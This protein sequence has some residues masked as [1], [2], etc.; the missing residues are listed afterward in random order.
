LKL[1]LPSNPADIREHSAHKRRGSDLL[2][3]LIMQL[4][5]FI[6]R[7]PGLSFALLGA[8]LFLLL[9]LLTMQ[10]SF[11]GIVASAPV[12]TTQP[13]NS[14]AGVGEDIAFGVVAIGQPPLHYQWRF[15]GGNLAGETNSTLL[16]T[17]LSFGRAGIYSVV[18]TNSF[19]STNSTNAILTIQSP[20]S[21]RLENGRV[22]Q[23]GSQVAVPIILR[24]TGR[25]HAV[26]F[27][28]LYNA[29]YS[30]PVFHPANGG[31]AVTIDTAQPGVVGVALTLPPGEVFP[32]GSPWVGLFQFDLAPG[33]GPL[34]GGLAFTTNPVMIAAANTNGLALSL[35]AAIEPQFALVTSNPQLRAQTGLFEQQL[36]I[37]NP[38]TN[39][40]VPVNI[41]ALG[42]GVDSRSNRI[43]FYN[44]SGT[45]PSLP[46][47]DPYVDSA[48]DCACGFH[49]DDPSGSTCDFTS[50][51]NCGAGNCD[52]YVTNFADLKFAQ[53]YNLGPGQSQTVTLEFYVADHFT[54]PNPKYSV[55]FTG[56][57]F[58]T[59]P[60]SSSKAL[61]AVLRETNGLFLVEFPTDLGKVY[62]VQYADTIEGLQTNALTATPP[63]N[64]TGSR[65]QW[66]D[67]GPPRTQSPPES[68]ARYYRVL[69]SQ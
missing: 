6:F 24:A 55:Y 68:G 61:A 18:V 43:T 57:P 37:G 33:A 36:L 47:S 26:S 54:V 34:Q 64:G 58:F 27:S 5:L 63:V 25:E 56:S 8:A 52:A 46:F 50:Y 1:T 32:A 45:L 39:V 3:Y 35:S 23:I 66:L 48:C 15:N 7:R 20:P 69:Q 9:G 41:L 29:N 30:N 19:G 21:R 40:V 13:S 11:A 38:G 16:M 2:C 53:I 4:F 17:N 60:P 49:L 42:L 44:S 51:L 62:Y 59:F 31:S 10:R 22:V 12:I 14:V 28:L 65:V 67:T